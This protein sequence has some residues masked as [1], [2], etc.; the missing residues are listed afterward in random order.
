MI[1]MRCDRLGVALFGALSLL[2]LLGL[3]VAGAFASTLLD[4]RSA[5][6]VHTDAELSAAADYALHA[7]LGEWDVGGFA[8]IPLG[9]TRSTSS[10]IPDNSMKATVTATSLPNGALWLAAT[11]TSAFGNE[12]RRVN[13]TARFPFVA[14]QP[15]AALTAAGDVMLGPD[16][17]FAVDSTGDKDCARA[18]IGDLVMAPAS[19][20]DLADTTGPPITVTRSNTASDSAHYLLGVDLLNRRR[21]SRVIYV[22]G[23]TTISGG[24]ASNVLFVAAGS[25]RITGPF[26]FS[27][28]MIAG[29]GVD[30]TLGDT[31]I[32]GAVLAFGAPGAIALRLS[33]ATVEFAPCITMRALKMAHGPHRV[34]ARGWAELY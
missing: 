22:A 34:R 23:D 27:G 5:R 6:F 21:A 2:T 25:I 10:V 18:P 3:L 28:V 19:Q 13:V 16:V 32:R 26:D 31:R 14:F 9:E 7:A 24:S 17:R 15:D 29:R 30:A 8:D 20:L 4:R 33:R 1:A 11:I 12:M